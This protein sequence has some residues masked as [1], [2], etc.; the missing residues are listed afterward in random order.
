MNFFLLLR[1][2]IILIHFRFSSS[3]C[4]YIIKVFSLTGVKKARSGEA[5]WSWAGRTGKHRS[6]STPKHWHAQKEHIIISLRSVE[7]EKCRALAG[8]LERVKGSTNVKSFTEIFKK[9]WKKGDFLFFC[10]SG[11]QKKEKDWIFIFF[12]WFGGVW[13]RV[14][15]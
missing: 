7:R 13:D 6:G 5:V 8:Q 4:I 12:F 10:S 3:H 11:T 1:S 9:N 2:S 15:L 14:V